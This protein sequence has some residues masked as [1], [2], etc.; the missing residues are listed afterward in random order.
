MVH[1]KFAHTG[2]DYGLLARCCSAFEEKAVQLGHSAY[3]HEN[4]KR[5]C[6]RIYLRS[7]LGAPAHCLGHKTGYRTRLEALVIEVRPDHH[8][9]TCG[10]SQMVDKHDHLEI[11]LN[12]KQLFQVMPMESRNCALHLEGFAATLLYSTA[13]ESFHQE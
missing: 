8:L 6:V 12:L 13:P 3:K 9:R 11:H 5:Y 7:L 10:G 1:R 2:M 4:Q